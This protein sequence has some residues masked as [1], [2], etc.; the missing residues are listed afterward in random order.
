MMNKREVLT[1][2]NAR[3]NMTPREW[4][5]LECLVRDES[6][7]RIGR[8]LKTSAGVARVW[9]HDLYRKLGVRSRTGAAV[10]AL[11]HGGMK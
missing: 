6:A 11:R 10:W 1:L 4:L 2:V 9:L 5:M 3:M 7:E 8:R